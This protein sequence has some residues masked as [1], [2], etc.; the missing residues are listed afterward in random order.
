MTTDLEGL[1]EEIRQLHLKYARGDLRERPFQNAVAERSVDLFR[2]VIKQR[3]ASDEVILQE[4]HVIQSHF[5]WTRSVLREPEQLSSSYFATDRRLIRLRVNTRP[6]S[7]VRC[8]SSDQCM[9]DEAPYERILEIRTMREIRRGE[10]LAG[11]AIAGVGLLFYSWLTITGPFM[12]GLGVL[13]IMHAL[14]L[15]TRWAEVRTEGI[16][17]Q[18]CILIIAPGKRS[19]RR[20]IKLLRKKTREHFPSKQAV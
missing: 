1:R 17:P 7:P 3:L 9:V 14:L 20:L 15:P 4:H 19:G 10:A 8:D 18:E 16:P 5:K 13:G 12:I 2:A 11:V 6:D